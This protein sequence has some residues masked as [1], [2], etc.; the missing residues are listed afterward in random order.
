[1]SDLSLHF[2]WE[3]AARSQTA[4]KRGIDN[5]LPSG[6]RVNVQ[7]VADEMERVRKLLGDMPLKIN[8]W[9][10]CPELNKAIGGSPKSAHMKGLAVDFEPLHMTNAEAFKLIAHSDVDFDQ[11]IHERTRSGADWIHLGLSEGPSRRQTLAAA[12]DT[13]GGPMTFTRVELG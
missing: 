4:T 11:L 10:R 7:R 3:E 6:L 8:S 9:Y 2:T 12:G 1:M 5:S 13:L